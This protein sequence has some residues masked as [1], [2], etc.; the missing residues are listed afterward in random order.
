M[1]GSNISE[2][3]WITA[4]KLIDLLSSLHPETII[5]ANEHYNLSPY[6]PG[7]MPEKYIGVINIRTEE[8]TAK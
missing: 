2:S 6:E 8:I 7:G 4:S 3:K 5:A 1:A